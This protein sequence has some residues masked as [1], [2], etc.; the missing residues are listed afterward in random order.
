MGWIINGFIDEQTV[1]FTV[2]AMLTNP[3]FCLRLGI[4]LRQEGTVFPQRF[5]GEVERMGVM[6]PAIQ[7]RIR[8]GWMAQGF[9]PVGDRQLAGDHRRVGLVALVQ[10]GR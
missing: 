3:F 2:P 1:V 10:W 5:P 4:L 8:Q 6:D 9:M 7:D